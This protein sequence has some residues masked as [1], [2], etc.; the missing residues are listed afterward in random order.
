MSEWMESW[1]DRRCCHK[2]G[3]FTSR[4]FGILNSS[5][6]WLDFRIKQV[7]TFRYW[8]KGEVIF[9][10]DALCHSTTALSKLAPSLIR[11]SLS[12]TLRS[13]RPERAWAT[14]RPGARARPCRLYTGWRVR[15]CAPCTTGIDARREA[16]HSCESLDPAYRGGKLK[17]FSKNTLIWG[18]ENHSKTTSRW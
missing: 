7:R 16:G 13:L 2:R 3:R 6:S 1:N 14:R 4:S 10:F 5:W 9:T 11:L 12:S 18:V 8:L 15:D 17:L